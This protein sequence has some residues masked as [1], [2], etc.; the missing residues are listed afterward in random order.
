MALFLY[1]GVNASGSQVKGEMQAGNRDE[2]VSLLRKKKIR[3]VSI[4]KKPVSLGFSLGS[5]VKL[6][7]ISRLTRQLSAMTAAGL[8]LPIC[9]NDRFPIIPANAATDAHFIRLRRVRGFPA[10]SA[11]GESTLFT[12]SSTRKGVE[13]VCHSKA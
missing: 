2:V 11:I 10:I 4:K 7:D 5:G 6:A 3:P 9:A 13:Q 1:V 8:P 12:C